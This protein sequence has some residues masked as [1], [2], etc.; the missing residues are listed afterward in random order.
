MPPDLSHY[1]VGT[2]GGLVS[3]IITIAAVKT[4]LVWIKKIL[5]SLTNTVNSQG[6]RIARLEGRDDHGG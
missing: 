3:A 2:V 5:T 4:D 1:V 6:E